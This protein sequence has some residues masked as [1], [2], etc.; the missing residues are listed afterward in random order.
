MYVLYVKYLS[1]SC[2]DAFLAAVHA[3]IA[4]TGTPQLSY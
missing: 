3:V 2:K 4:L 1:S